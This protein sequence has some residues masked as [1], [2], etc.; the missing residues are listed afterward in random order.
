MA[1]PSVGAMLFLERYLHPDR[2]AR[3][4]Y[5]GNGRIRH[6]YRGPRLLQQYSNARLQALHLS[7]PADE[8]P[9][10][11]EQM[12]RN[13]TGIPQRKPIKE[14]QPWGGKKLDRKKAK[15]AKASPTD[16]KA[17]GPESLGN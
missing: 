7:A 3:Q 6:P 11:T 14:R 5:P 12:K 1:A 2:C 17:N 13:T 15:K 4:H 16:E 9:A 10:A 8:R